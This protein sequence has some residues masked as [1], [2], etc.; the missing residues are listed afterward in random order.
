MSTREQQQIK[1]AALAETLAAMSLNTLAKSTNTDTVMMICNGDKVV[2]M[3][4]QA[5]DEPLEVESVLHEPKNL[6]ENTD[7]LIKEMEGALYG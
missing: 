5:R 4:N 7:E 1:R 3:Q 2:R 6:P